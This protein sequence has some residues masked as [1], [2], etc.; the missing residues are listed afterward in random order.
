MAVELEGYLNFIL[1]LSYLMPFSL[2]K[3]PLVIFHKFTTYKVVFDLVFKL[4]NPEY[5]R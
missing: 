3:L 1:Q 5:F 4:L 2:K